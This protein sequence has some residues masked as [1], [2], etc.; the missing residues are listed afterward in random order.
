MN[1]YSAYT[2]ILKLVYY[3]DRKELYYNF[4]PF[5][6]GNYY[7]MKKIYHCFVSETKFNNIQMSHN[8]VCQAWLPFIIFFL[9]DTMN[10]LLLS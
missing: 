1:L 8:S 7:F 10:L 5:L 6:T 9:P 2:F 4:F 3:G